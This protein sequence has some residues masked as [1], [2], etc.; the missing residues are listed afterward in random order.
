LTIGSGNFIDVV[1][2]ALGGA[3]TNFNPANSYKWIIATGIGS[4]S[5]PAVA[6][7]FVLDTSAVSVFNSSIGGQT[8]GDFSIGEDTGDVY[9]QYTATPEPT[10][11][12]LLGV[13]IGGLALRRRRRRTSN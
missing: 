12:A 8:A 11:M 5:A 1:P 13:G 2:I 3:S 6:S 7:Q 4:G 9:V 10:S